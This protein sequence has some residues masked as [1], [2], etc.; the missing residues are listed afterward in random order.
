MNQFKLCQ[1]NWNFLDMFGLA[2][3]GLVKD[4]QIVHK[5]CGMGRLPP[6]F[7]YDD[8]KRYVLY[9]FEANIN[10]FRS[11][12]T[13]IIHW[14]PCDFKFVEQLHTLNLEIP[15]YDIAKVIIRSLDRNKRHWPPTRSRYVLW[16][17]SYSYQND[18]NLMMDL[19]PDG[20][21]ISYWNAAPKSNPLPEYT[22]QYYQNISTAN[23]LFEHAK[24]FRDSCIKR[25]KLGLGEAKPF[26]LSLVYPTSKLLELAERIVMLGDSDFLHP[27]FLK[28]GRISPEDNSDMWRE[29]A[30]KRIRKIRS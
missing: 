18:R 5:S 27:D 9:R 4:W 16:N 26:Y 30:D 2:T 23:E 6:G 11:D 28:W 24:S 1:F 13:K 10:L 7:Y 21:V 14:D 17:L 29:G 12:A 8:S 20:V 22:L 15:K 25:R 3:D 19:F